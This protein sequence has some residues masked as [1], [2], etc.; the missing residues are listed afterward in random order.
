[1]NFDQIIIETKNI[2]TGYSTTNFIVT[3]IVGFSEN[4]EEW[5]KKEY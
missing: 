4:N 1:M 5:R 3:Y 2:L